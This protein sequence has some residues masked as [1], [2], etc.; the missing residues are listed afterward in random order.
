MSDGY[1]PVMVK[2]YMYLVLILIKLLFLLLY[3]ISYS[4]YTEQ[5]MYNLSLTN[6]S[7]IYYTIRLQARIELGSDFFDTNNVIRVI[8]NLKN[9]N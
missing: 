5:C 2:Y 4:Y 7:V 9:V 1:F 3:Q 6:V 8:I